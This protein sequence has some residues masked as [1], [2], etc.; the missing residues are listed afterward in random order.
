MLVG[1]LGVGPRPAA[2]PLIAVLVLVSR[3]D[4]QRVGEDR[5]GRVADV[6]ERYLGHGP[7]EP[8]PVRPGS[9]A[10]GQERV[11]VDWM[12]VGR[13]T[14]YLQLTEDLGVSRIGQVDDPQ[15]VNVAEGHEVG[16]VTHEAGA[17]NALAL[18][19][20][21]DVAYLNQLGGLV[22]AAL[23]NHALGGCERE[24]VVGRPG[25]LLGLEPPAAPGILGCSY[26][27]DTV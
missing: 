12:D 1:G 6:E 14:W 11:G 19:D 23:W 16:A 25:P 9:Y 4:R 18:G 26:A 17:P 24:H 21:V 13:D 2:A 3:R 20:V 7:V 15:G 10:D 27:D 8:E 5:V 22:I